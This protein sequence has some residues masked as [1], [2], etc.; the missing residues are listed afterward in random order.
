MLNA[1]TKIL[2]LKPIKYNKKMLKLSSKC[3]SG[4]NA[5][6]VFHHISP[7]LANRME[8]DIIYSR[9]FLNCIFLD[10]FTH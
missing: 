10:G 3:C 2:M 4:N 1:R 8:L 7:G 9:F 5:S 6:Q